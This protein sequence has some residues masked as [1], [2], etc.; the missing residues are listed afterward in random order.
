[1]EIIKRAGRREEIPAFSANL[2]NSLLN[3]IRR[4]PLT[5]DDLL[6]LTAKEESELRRYLDIL[7][8]EKKVQPV[9][10]GGR[11]FYREWPTVAAGS[12]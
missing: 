11:I 12:D 2:E 5:L 8:R 4:R 3:T 1:M 10:T 9:I 6:A 7:E